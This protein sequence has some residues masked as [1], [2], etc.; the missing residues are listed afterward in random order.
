MAGSAVA[1]G[2]RTMSAK[3][4]ADRVNGGAVVTK[5]TKSP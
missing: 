5:E 2:R 4:L 3:E 1:K